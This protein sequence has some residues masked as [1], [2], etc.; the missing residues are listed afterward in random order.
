MGRV[1]IH[2]EAGEAGRQLD[3]GGA[4]LILVLG[5]VLAV[6]HQQR[7]L[8]GIGVRAHAVARLE[9]GRCGGQT[10]AVGRNGAVGVGGHLGADRGQAAAQFGGFVS[11]YGRLG[12]T[13]NGQGEGSSQ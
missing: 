11:G 3:G 5:D 8:A 4:Q 12:L 7:L 10:T 2:A 9:A 6:D 1:D 13:G